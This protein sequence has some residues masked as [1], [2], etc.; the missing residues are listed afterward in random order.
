MRQNKKQKKKEVKSGEKKKKLKKSEKT[1]IERSCEGSC[2]TVLTDVHGVNRVWTHAVGVACTKMRKRTRTEMSVLGLF[3][4]LIRLLRGGED[5]R[6][7]QSQVLKRSL[8][9][10]FIISR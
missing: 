9:H 5:S 7:K 1:K 3:V 4:S 8:L 10:E 2:G 6:R